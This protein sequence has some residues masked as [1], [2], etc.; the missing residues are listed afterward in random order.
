MK[1]LFTILLL[2]FCVY[3]YAQVKTYN[4]DY[5]LIYVSESFFGADDTLRFL[6]N[7]EVTAIYA[8]VTR[9][10]I[11]DPSFTP[12]I[13]FL[14]LEEGM[15]GFKATM[16]GSEVY[17]E[18]TLMELIT[19]G[20]FAPPRLFKDDDVKMIIAKKKTQKAK[21]FNGKAKT[22]Y[23]IPADKED[24]ELEVTVDE[25]YNLNIQAILAFTFNSLMSSDV[26]FK[27][28]PNGLVVQ[29]G[30]NFRLVEFEEKQQEVRFGSEMSITNN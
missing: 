16:D 25:R 5:D 6:V 13:M 17:M 20:G 23:L 21:Y 29:V 14:D 24:E 10:D 9:V 27:D 28:I 22:Y 4:F 12:S 11:N 19:V 7:E 15:I 3:S 1:Q 30:P 2:F 26:E 18:A 8:D